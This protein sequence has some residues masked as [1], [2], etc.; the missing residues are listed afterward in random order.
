MGKKSKSKKKGGRKKPSGGGRAATQA[1]NNN[2]NTMQESIDAYLEGAEMAARLS[3][4]DMNEYNNYMN[5]ETTEP[6]TPSS[7]SNDHNN[8][9][10][11]ILPHSIS[12]ETNLGVPCW[13][14]DELPAGKKTGWPNC[15]VC[16][17]PNSSKFC[18]KC[19]EWNLPFEVT[20]SRECFEKDY[21]SHVTRMH[22]PEG[23]WDAYKR[24][25]L[26]NVM[27]HG[28]IDALMRVEEQW[29]HPRDRLNHKDEVQEEAL[30]TMMERINR[31]FPDVGSDDDDESDIDDE[32]EESDVYG[33]ESSN[34]ESDDDESQDDSKR[35]KTSVV[36]KFAFDST[37]QSVTS[38]PFAFG[39]SSLTPATEST[40][41]NVFTF[42][43]A[44]STP[45]AGK[46][47][48]DSSE[49]KTLDAKFDDVQTDAMVEILSY[50]TLQELEQLR[51]VSTSFH[52]ASN[53][54]KEYIHS[55]L[56]KGVSVEIVGLK[57]ERGKQL[58]GRLA[59]IDG[60]IIN[61]RYP[62]KILHLTGK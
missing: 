7:S 60:R 59:L 20:C 36:P 54:R 26:G 30:R 16:G 22:R 52:E 12:L 29:P 28:G 46:S 45:D 62:T 55:L 4:I 39:G 53:K 43:A 5:G 33:G 13:I 18:P 10:N 48:M 58:N 15:H 44:G 61:G 11:N 35:M 38:E 49:L 19:V 40:S 21:S 41:R 32:E 47:D 57:S 8:N 23:E 17:K 50:F 1:V 51:K 3:G 24:Y 14:I 31:E 9:N 6:P 25:I 37:K 56:K 42:G 2:D 27:M 34:N